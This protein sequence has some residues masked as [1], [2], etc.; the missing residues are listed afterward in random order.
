VIS[1][2]FHEIFGHNPVKMQ[3]F[4]IGKYQFVGHINNKQSNTVRRFSEDC[5]CPVDSAG[6]TS[7]PLTVDQYDIS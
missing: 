1:K 7:F 4:L 3:R 2:S 6:G 5:K